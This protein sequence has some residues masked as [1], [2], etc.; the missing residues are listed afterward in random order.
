MHPSRLAMP[1]P[2][3]KSPPQTLAAVRKRLLELRN[4]KD[5]EFLQRFFKTTPGQYGAGDK[6]LGIRVPV[7][8]ELAREFQ[9]LPLED[10]A[11][12]LKDKWHEA[13]LLAVILLGNRY[14]KGSAAERKKIFDLYVANAE[15]VN[16]W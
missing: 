16:N 11:L 8:R 14:T 12:L 10:I 3:A 15:R 9:D 13:R 7:T 4:P 2:I 6:F 5:A 1:K